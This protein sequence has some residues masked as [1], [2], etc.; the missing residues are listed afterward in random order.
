M[1]N[2]VGFAS[3]GGASILVSHWVRSDHLNPTSRGEPRNP[4]HGFAKRFCNRLMPGH[5]CFA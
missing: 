5:Y 1:E 4:P 3:I 2:T